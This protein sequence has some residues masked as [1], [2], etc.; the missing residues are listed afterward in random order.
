[1]HGLMNRYRKPRRAGRLKTAALQL[2]FPMRWAGLCKGAN[3]QH[4]RSAHH[5]RIDSYAV[6]EASPP[7]TTDVRR[8]ILANPFVRTRRAPRYVRVRQL[9]LMACSLGE[10]RLSWLPGNSNAQPDLD[11]GFS[12]LG[13]DDRKLQRRASQLMTRGTQNSVG[14]AAASMT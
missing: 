1:M 3:S 9:D 4:S 7:W 12:A 6:F 13:V 2:G 8:F 14:N 5:V 11:S 10:F